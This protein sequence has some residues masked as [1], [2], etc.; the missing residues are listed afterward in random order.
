MSAKSHPHPPRSRDHPTVG[1]DAESRDAAIAN[2]SGSAS[3]SKMLFAY[4]TVNGVLGDLGSDGPVR[5]WRHAL[6]CVGLDDLGLP[7]RDRRVASVRPLA[8][9][10][11]PADHRGGHPARNQSIAR[12]VASKRLEAHGQVHWPALVV[13]RASAT[14]MS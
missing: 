1:A 5:G 13:G 7:P 2:L 10:P 4:V 14:T 8:R 3:S 12:Q 6:A 9:K 11:A